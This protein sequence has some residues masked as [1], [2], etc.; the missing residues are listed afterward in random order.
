MAASFTRT[1]ILYIFVVTALRVMGKRQ[2]G[3]LQPSELVVAIMISDLASIPISNK[4]LPLWEGIIPI[5]TLV[6]VEML[7]SVLVIKSEFLRMLITGRPTIIVRRGRMEQTALKKLRLS[8]DDLLEQLRLM[9]YSD[10]SEV[11][12]VM[13]ETNGQLSV[14]PKEISRPV[15]C[16]DLK[17]NPRQTHLPH[18][19]VADGKIRKSGLKAAGIS[20]SE[21][22]SILKKNGASGP[23]EVFYM[24]LTDDKKVFI[25]KKN[26]KR[27]K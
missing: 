1:L 15:T 5:L 10:I 17:I 8:I 7:F 27:R 16:E 13:L 3:E 9:G 14:I 26:K 23:E 18:T 4:E 22:V 12:T 21:A 20:R 6:V 25:E 24:N 11:D 19:I 2:L